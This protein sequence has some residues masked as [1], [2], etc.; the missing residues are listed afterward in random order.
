M[1]DFGWKQAGECAFYAFTAS[2]IVFMVLYGFL[3]PWWRSPTGRNIML[4]MGLLAVTSGYFTTAYWAGVSPV[5]DY[6]IRFF[7][8]SGLFVAVSWRVVLFVREQIL[9]RRS[10]RSDERTSK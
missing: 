2:S 3:S 8:F 4:V 1:D 9:A 5:L 7:L 6:P 10:D